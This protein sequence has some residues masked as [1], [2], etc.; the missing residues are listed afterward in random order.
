[1]T[2]NNDSVVQECTDVDDIPVVQY[3]FV[4]ISEIANLEPNAT[5]GN[6]SI[7]I[8]RNEQTKS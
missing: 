1:M 8:D 5:V 4:P 7:Q 6:V 3:N 2:L